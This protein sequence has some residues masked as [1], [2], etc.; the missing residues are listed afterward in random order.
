[1]S[2]FQKKKKQRFLSNEVSGPQ[3]VSMFPYRNFFEQG[4]SHIL[5]RSRLLMLRLEPKQKC[6]RLLAFE[7]GKLK[8]ATL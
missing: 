3:I 4:P 8:R 7:E 5:N 2:E 6:S 1:M